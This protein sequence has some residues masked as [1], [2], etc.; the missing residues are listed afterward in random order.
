MFCSRSI[1]RSNECW[2]RHRYQYANR[3]FSVF[4]HPLTD[5]SGSGKEG[6]PLVPFSTVPQVN[7]TESDVDTQL[8]KSND[9]NAF[10]YF[11]LFAFTQF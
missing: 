7:E 9:K 5:N 11:C 6:H 10:A 1:S 2:N 4:L 8:Y 3:C